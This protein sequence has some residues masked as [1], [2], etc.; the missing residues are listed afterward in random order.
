MVP[1]FK[2]SKGHTG[3]FSM[4]VGRID[5]S[6]LPVN[7]FWK[8]EPAA[9]SARY[10]LAPKSSCSELSLTGLPLAHRRGRETGHFGYTK[11]Y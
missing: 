10:A 4:A 5:L 1:H 2:C 3:P 9:A 6:D 8:L 7:L 11:G